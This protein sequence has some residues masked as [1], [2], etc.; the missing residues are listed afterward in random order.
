MPES[1]NF[2]S[3]GNRPWKNTSS[4]NLSDSRSQLTANRPFAYQKWPFKAL[5]WDLRLADTVT[6]AVS[7]Y[8]TENINSAITGKAKFYECI[9][10]PGGKLQFFGENVIMQLLCLPDGCHEKDKTCYLGEEWIVMAFSQK[11]SLFLMHHNTRAIA[12]I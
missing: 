7:Y 12:S 5:F 3:R 9:K 11:P 8:N 6:L 1:Q 2:V 10:Q 4:Q